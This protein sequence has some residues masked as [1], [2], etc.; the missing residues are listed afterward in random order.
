MHEA[1]RR[2]AELHAVIGRLDAV[3]DGIAHHVYERIGDSFDHV[4][5]EFGVLTRHFKFDILAGLARDVTNEP[6]PFSGTSV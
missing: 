1:L 6:A 4:A 5:V 3:I 2:L